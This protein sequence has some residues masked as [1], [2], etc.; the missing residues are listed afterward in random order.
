[1]MIDEKKGSSL[2]GS[3]KL[4]DK[5]SLFNPSKIYDEKAETDIHR[6]RIIRMRVLSSI[7][8]PHFLSFFYDMIFYIFCCFFWIIP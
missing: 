7:V 6:Q 4:W 1:M 3:M 8:Q 5:K 2:K